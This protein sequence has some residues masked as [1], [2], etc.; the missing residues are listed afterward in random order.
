MDG[1]ADDL[2]AGLGALDLKTPR[3]P[4]TPRAAAKSPATL[5]GTERG[6]SAK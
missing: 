1:Y 5:D 6:G 2:A 4:A 3:S